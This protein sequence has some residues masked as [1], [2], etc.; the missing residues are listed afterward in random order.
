MVQSKNP[1]FTNFSKK[2]FTSP[3]SESLIPRDFNIPRSPFS[4][5]INT[6]RRCS[7]SPRSK[8]KAAPKSSMVCDS[9]LQNMC[10]NNNILTNEYSHSQ[11]LPDNAIATLSTPPRGCKA[12]LALL[13]NNFS[14]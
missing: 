7:K 13:P 11:D 3:N 10:H 2:N 9:I 14:K 8:C 5:A 4:T 6:E 12:S 1:V